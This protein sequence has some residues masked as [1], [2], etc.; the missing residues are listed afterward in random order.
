MTRTLFKDSRRPYFWAEK[1]LLRMGLSATA[2]AYYCVLADAADSQDRCWPS[3][4]RISGYLRI[5]RRTAIRVAKELV[6]KGAVRKRL[7]VDPKSGHQVVC[8]ELVDLPRASSDGDYM[9]PVGD[10]QSPLGDKNDTGSVTPE[11]LYQGVREQGIEEEANCPI[12][13]DLLL[14]HFSVGFLERAHHR[15]RFTRPQLEDWRRLRRLHPEAL[16]RAKIDAW[17]SHPCTRLTGNRPF[18]SFLQWF[19]DIAIPQYSTE[20]AGIPST[21]MDWK[22]EMLAASPQGVGRYQ[23]LVHG[24]TDHDAKARTVAKEIDCDEQESEQIIAICDPP[25][26]GD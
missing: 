17:W 15:P 7:M 5:S 14:E 9:S 22:H 26:P 8:Y 23:Q 20:P 25:R 19:D 21:D 2:I 13:A 1:G 16:L 10:T 4:R 24:I 6:S 12:L 18:G 3:Y 11:H